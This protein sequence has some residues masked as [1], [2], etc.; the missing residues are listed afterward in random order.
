MR[1]TYENVYIGSFI[2]SLGYLFKSSTK[3]AKSP[4]KEDLSSVSIDLY[5][6]VASAEKVIGD[7]LTS[8]GGKNII[9]E[10]KRDHHGLKDEFEK[11]S[12]ENLRQLLT[13]ESDIKLQEI[14]SRCHFLSFA[15]RYEGGDSAL[16]FGSYIG[17]LTLRD[18]KLLGCR[19]FCNKYINT[20][21]N[22][23][24]V[25]HND[26]KVYV[27]K[28]TEVTGGTCGGLAISLNEDGVQSMVVFDDINELSESLTVAE[29]RAEKNIL[30]REPSDSPGSSLTMG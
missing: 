24:G 10:F 26:F 3:E 17:F 22:E 12:K 25:D 7:L 13:N 15:S 29:E 18:E 9:I 2:F 4:T 6:Q 1:P 16:A 19:E 23:I 11:K 30:S 20:E 28:L 21:N 27:N 8:V 14:S 5:Q